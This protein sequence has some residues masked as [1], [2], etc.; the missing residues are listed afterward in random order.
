MIKIYTALVTGASRGIGLAIAGKFKKNG[1]KV[2]VPTRGEM[3]L[4]SNTSI[5]NYL[6]KLKQP[7]DILVNDA[8]INPLNDAVNITD[9]D[10]ETTLQ[11]NLIAPIRI[12][13]AII[14]GMIKQQYGRIVNISS[15][16]SIVTKPKRLIYSASKSGLSAATRTMAVELS[17][18]N[19]MVN[20]VAPGFT[21]TEMTRKN[22]SQKVIAEIEKLIPIG[23]L[24][25]PSEIAEVVAF[26]ASENNTYLTGQ[27]IY[28]DGGYTS[29]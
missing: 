7:I 13:R 26:L 5:D 16:W 22:N 4:L 27:T 25:K 12:C 6:R 15:I 17:R 23:R 14:P 19:I 3:D 10:I 11:V 18:Y 1:Y 8:G 9:E 21:D 2:I 28:V 29:T 20:A 24:A